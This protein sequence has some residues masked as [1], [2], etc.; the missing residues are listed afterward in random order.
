MNLHFTRISEVTDKVTGTSKVYVHAHH[1]GLNLIAITC[2]KT[3]ANN[4]SRD[5]LSW[6]HQSISGISIRLDHALQWIQT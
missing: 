4:M 2:I 1:A 3:H 6:I 5:V